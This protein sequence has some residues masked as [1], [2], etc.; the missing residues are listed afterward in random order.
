M[1]RARSL[2]R[3][4]STLTAATVVMLMVSA[5]AP[6]GSDDAEAADV[7]VAVALD[8][9]GTSWAD[10]G[11]SR[12]SLHDL[13]YQ[14]MLRVAELHNGF[15]S[16]DEKALFGNQVELALTVL[17]S[18]TQAHE[19][20]LRDTANRGYQLVIGVGMAFSE[21]V[22]KIARD[23][24]E[25]HFVLVEGYLPDLTESENVTVVQFAENEG[26]FLAGALAGLMLPDLGGGTLGFLGAMDMPQIRAHQAGFTAGAMYTTDALPENDMVAARYISQ[27]PTA[28][29]D[30]VAAAR[31]A[32]EMFQDG[33]RIIFHSAGTS[34]EGIFQAA[35]EERRWA[36]GAERDQG[37]VYAT[38]NTAQERAIGERIVTSMLKRF[39]V[40][41]VRIMEEFIASSSEFRGGYRVY[42]IADEVFTYAV[43]RFNEDTLEPYRERLAE[44]KELVASGEVVVPESSGEIEAWA[45][46]TF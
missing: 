21:A 44:L 28:F 7:R 31:V 13:L 30:P 6:R 1:R 25:T 43:N 34:S 19:Q 42:G 35:Y 36:I 26:A 24:P 9:T 8:A 4:I 16:G 11:W 33:V 29:N 20:E 5:C 2:R 37:I 39:D 17:E 46:S 32:A 15:V 23:F 10:A 27:D 38:A 12:D 41:L 22:S 14:G 3:I 18:G 45:E 40:A